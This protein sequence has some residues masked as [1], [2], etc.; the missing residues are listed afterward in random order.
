[1]GD[2]DT[3]LFHLLIDTQEESDYLSPG[4]VSRFPVVSSQISIGG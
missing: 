1:M 3:D 2:N 4:D